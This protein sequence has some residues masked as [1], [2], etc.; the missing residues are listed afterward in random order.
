[1]TAL[2]ERFAALK[3]STRPAL[4][5]DDA[6][7]THWG[8]KSLPFRRNV[9]KTPR[10]KALPDKVPVASFNLSALTL[11][12]ALI[13]HKGSNNSLTPAAGGVSLPL[14]STGVSDRSTGE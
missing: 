6:A 5:R 12:R 8:N 14:A 9:A 11:M 13:K 4:I 10:T 3:S 1:M 2:P 7:P